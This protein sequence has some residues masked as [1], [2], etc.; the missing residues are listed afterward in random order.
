M[1]TLILELE[2]S[3]E[4][5]RKNCVRLIQKIYE[6]DPLTCPK[7]QGRMRIIA[8][9]ENEDLRG[10]TRTSHSCARDGGDTAMPRLNWMNANIAKEM[11]AHRNISSPHF[12]R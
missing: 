6:T 12:K 4:E 11:N 2:E 1:D 8:F 10:L 5:H 3:F 7:Y 9:I